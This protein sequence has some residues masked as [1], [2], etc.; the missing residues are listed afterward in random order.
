[1]ISY[2]FLILI[3]GL[4]ALIGIGFHRGK[5]K[6]N[7]IYLSAFSQLVDI[8]KPHDQT[9]IDIGGLVGHH[10]SFTIEQRGGIYKIDATITLLP[11]HAPLY[12][13]ISRRLMRSDRLF[14]TFY[15]RASPPGEGHLIE[16]SYDGF[17]GHEITHA[18]W[19]T[20]EKIAWGAHE[21]YLYYDRI[22]MA[23]PLK[24]LIDEHPDPGAVKHIALLPGQKKGFVFMIPSE[25]A[26]GRQIEPV[27]RWMC[28][29]FEL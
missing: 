18:S 5:K 16:A 27:F 29:I 13:P 7:A 3:F 4:S 25:G 22:T 2:F 28:R 14:V 21:Y 19:L 1:M 11:R 20:R 24:R 8:F 6:N 17:R 9:F 26:V 15:T 23:K 10:A 12:M